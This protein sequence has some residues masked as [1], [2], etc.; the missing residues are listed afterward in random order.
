MRGR[1]VTATH[2]VLRVALWPAG[3]AVLLAAALPSPLAAHEGG[4]AAG[5]L[6]GFYHATLGVDHVIA[7]VLVGIWGAQLGWL[8]I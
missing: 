5:L 6:S 3:V 8:A 2:E 1:L 4:S 7:M